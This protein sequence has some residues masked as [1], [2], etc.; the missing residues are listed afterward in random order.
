MPRPLTNFEHLARYAISRQAREFWAKRA[1][2]AAAPP[3][4]HATRRRP[5]KSKPDQS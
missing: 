4:R 2:R 3:V 5:R 1:E